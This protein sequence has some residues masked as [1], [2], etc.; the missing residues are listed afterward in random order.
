MNNPDQLVTITNPTEWALTA[1]DVV[2][3]L[4]DEIALAGGDPAARA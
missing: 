2:V 4:K 1:S 3:F